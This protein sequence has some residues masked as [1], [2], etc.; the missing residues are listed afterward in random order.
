ML[1]LGAPAGR[2]LG[3]GEQA[4]QAV[5][6]RRRDALMRCIGVL[7]GGAYDGHCMIEAGRSRAVR[8]LGGSVASDSIYL[9]S[10]EGLVEM[11][12]EP[13]ESENLLQEL[14]A[15]YP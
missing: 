9:M 3:I 6:S 11:K 8:C 10:E 5:R 13:Y 4:N 12:N 14:L 1:A 2:S 15:Q 7:A